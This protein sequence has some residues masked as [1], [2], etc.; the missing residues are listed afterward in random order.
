MVEPT[1]FQE[2]WNHPDPIQCEKLRT[3][4]RKEFHDMSHRKVCG[5]IERIEMPPDR[6]CVKTKWVFKIK[7]NGIFRAR[8]VAFHVV[9]TINFN[10]TT[11]Q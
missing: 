1:K 8:L 7:R 9:Y 11:S 10:V 2:S 4:F 3:D 5:K 6:R